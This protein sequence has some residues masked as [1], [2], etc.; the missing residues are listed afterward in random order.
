MLTRFARKL[1]LLVGL[2]AGAAPAVAVAEEAAMGGAG[3]AGD[4]LVGFRGIGEIWQDPGILQAYRSSR[5]AGAAFGAIGITGWLR[6]EAEL[7]YMRQPSQAGRTV[8][9]ADGTAAAI[10]AGSLELLPV[11]LGLA[12]HKDTGRAEVFGGLGYAM[13]VFAERTD[14]GTVA[15]TKPALDLRGGVRIHTQLVQPRTRPT[16]PTGVQGVDVELLLGRRQHH[17]FGMGEGFDFSAWRVG[18]GLVCRL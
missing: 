7:G 9:L 1:P 10:S 14:T 18:A 12:A 5:F 16:G 3:G 11:T 15:G 17:A 6:A 8:T 13:A 4:L 2:L